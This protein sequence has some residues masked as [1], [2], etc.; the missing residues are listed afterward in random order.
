MKICDH[1]Y[2]LREIRATAT[3][4][5]ANGLKKTLMLWFWNA[6]KKRERRSTNLLEIKW[7]KKLKAKKIIDLMK[8]SDVKSHEKSKRFDQIMMKCDNSKKLREI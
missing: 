5:N 4:I 1:S 8:G 3:H 2:K 6:K 7:W